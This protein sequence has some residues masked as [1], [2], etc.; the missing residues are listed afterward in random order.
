LG[1]AVGKHARRSFLACSPEFLLTAIKRAEDGRG[2]IVRGYE[3]RGQTHRVTMRLPGEV[4]QVQ[5]ANLLE[6]AEETLPVSRGGVRFLCRPH[7]I[8]TLLLR[9]TGGSGGW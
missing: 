2:L 7:E 3:T 9:P 8:V 1:A 6:E 4:R 5:R